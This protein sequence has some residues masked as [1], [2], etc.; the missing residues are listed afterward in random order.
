MVLSQRDADSSLADP[1]GYMISAEVPMDHIAETD[2]DTG[3]IFW[4]P[5]KLA[6]ITPCQGIFTAGHERAYT[7]VTHKNLPVERAHTS[8]YRK[9]HEPPDR[10]SGGLLFF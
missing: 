8:F 1:P 10:P 3:E 2:P 4:N 7:H 6:E 9:H 5:K